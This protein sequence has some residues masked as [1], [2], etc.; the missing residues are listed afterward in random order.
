MGWVKIPFWAWDFLLS[1]GWSV[2]DSYVK[3][4]DRDIIAYLIMLHNYHLVLIGYSSIFGMYKWLCN[5]TSQCRRYSLTCG[6]LQH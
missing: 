5:P 1:I 2:S 4:H 3:C 6:C